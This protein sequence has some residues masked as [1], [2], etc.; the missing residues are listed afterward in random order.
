MPT[1]VTA[2]A[3]GVPVGLSRTYVRLGKDDDFGYDAWCAALR[4]GRSYMS[5]GPLLSLS[6]DGASIGDT[7]QLP[8]TGGTVAVEATAAS[9]FPMFRLEL[10][11]SG[12]VIASSDSESGAHELQINEN[13]KIDKPGWI[14]ARVGG[15]GPEHLT[16]HQ[17]GFQ[18][19]IMAH[20]S[21]VYL[22]CGAQ[23][24][25]ADREALEHIKTLID[26]ARTY[27]E[28]RAAISAGT[29]VLHQPPGFNSRPVISG[30]SC[31]QRAE[32]PV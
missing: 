6:V 14:C 5:S 8:D 15:G 23:A 22:A 9:I 12:R 7:V 32:L 16:Q 18:R 11:H 30:F 21:P 1:M 17:D 26:R 13:V 4:A 3:G 10:V 27:V 24:S 19:A 29:D 20:T 2:L 31:V 28:N 25:P